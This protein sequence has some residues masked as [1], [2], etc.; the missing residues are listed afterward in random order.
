MTISKKV[1]TN[2]STGI[3]LFLGDRYYGQDY[4]RDLHYLRDR[5]G[6]VFQDILK[7]IP[8]IV[9]GGI[10]SQGSGDTLNIT[11]CVGYHKE[12]VTIPDTYS[13]IPPSS[14]TGVVEA[15]RVSST[16]QTNMAIASATLD[17]ATTNYV[18]LRYLET[19]G[20]TR[21]RARKT[22]TY[23]YEMIPS[24]EFVVSSVAPTDYE[25]CLTTFV[26]STGGS[27]TFTSYGTRRVP[28]DTALLGENLVT[29]QDEFDR[30][31]NG[32]IP[33]N[34]S[35]F[36]KKKSTPYL[37]NY[38][39]ALS[40]GVKITSDGAVV[41]RNSATARFSTTYKNSA[42]YS[43]G[44]AI[45]SKTITTSSHTPFE[46]GDIVS[47][48]NVE[49]YTVASDTG[50]E[51]EITTPIIRTAAISTV[52]S[53][54]RDIL[55]EGWIFDGQNDVNNLGGDYSA[56]FSGNGGAFYLDYCA[57]SKFLAE[58]RNCKATGNGG[59]YACHIDYPTYNL[60]IS[61]INNCSADLGGG[62]AYISFSETS[63]IRHCTSTSH[64]GGCYR[65]SSGKIFDISFC[66]SGAS[67]GGCYDCDWAEINAIKECSAVNGGGCFGSS[68]SK[69]SNVTG[70]TSSSTGGGCSGCDYCI[71]SFVRSCTATGNGGGCYNC[72]NCVISNII[73]C[74]GS[75]G[76]GCHTC[77]NAFLSG[78]F[79]NEGTVDNIASCSYM[80]QLTYINNAGT[81][82]HVQTTGTSLT[83]TDLH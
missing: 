78:Y 22:G 38:A 8:I 2:Y 83:T 45:G 73:A 77:A 13:T 79:D 57:N 18:K 43:S 66:V 51:I 65:C 75:S 42:T 10:V 37:L 68:Y 60:K 19:A 67:G 26:G 3:P 54:Q 49:F 41:N 32:T 23:S 52:F 17:G 55:T 6:C 70:C 24:F 46:A 56:G 9:S 4:V 21:A 33:A 59:A 69:I 14:T 61:N 58:V 62:C 1:N 81:A 15:V 30:L 74:T 11:A 53:F 40:S 28:E 31:F 36:L 27:F 64:G 25:V 76:G 48:N 7:D 12:S 47:W 39:V 82:T 16:Q 29:T 20:N 63:D 44:G 5:I 50:T 80:G 71:I 72:D 34:T 35:I